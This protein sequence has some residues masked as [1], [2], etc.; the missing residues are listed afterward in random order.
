MD[1]EIVQIASNNHGGGFSGVLPGTEGEGHVLVWN[2]LRRREL[3]DEVR[4]PGPPKTRIGSVYLLPHSSS[5]QSFLVS[6]A[7]SWKQSDLTFFFFAYLQENLEYPPGFD[8]E[9]PLTRFGSGSGSSF[10]P[11]DP[12]TRF[13]SGYDYSEDYASGSG[14]GY[15]Y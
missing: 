5:L 14:S 3:R 6:D 15:A 7:C 4:F 1:E 12:L 9:D 2:T 8:P 11:E 10:D 13:G